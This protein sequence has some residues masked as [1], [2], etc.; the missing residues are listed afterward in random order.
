MSAVSLVI[1]ASEVPP[2]PDRVKSTLGRSHYQEESSAPEIKGVTDQ[3]MY[4]SDGLKI[5]NLDIRGLGRDRES[6]G[7]ALFSMGSEMWKAVR[8]GCS[9]RRKDNS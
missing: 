2:G 3:L 6:E 7:G 8:P 9:P 4:H 1:R 5:L